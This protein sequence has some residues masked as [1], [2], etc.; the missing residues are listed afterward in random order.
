MSKYFGLARRHLAGAQVSQFSTGEIRNTSAP[1]PEVVGE[2]KKWTVVNVGGSSNYKNVVYN[3]QAWFI[4]Y[5]SNSVGATST[6]GASW[7]V[8]TLASNAYWYPAYGIRNAT[9]GVV[10]YSSNVFNYSTNNG[11]SWTS[12]TMPR[13]ND[14]YIA[15]STMDYC[16]IFTRGGTYLVY[17]TNGTSWTEYSM[18]ANHDVRCVGLG[19]NWNWMVGFQQTTGYKSRNGYNSWTSFTVPSGAKNWSAISGNGRRVLLF[20]GTTTGYYSDDDGGTWTS[21]SL[22]QGF[23]NVIWNG[24]VWLAH[25]LNGAYTS[26]DGITWTQVTSSVSMGYGINS[27]QGFGRQG[28]LTN[29]N[30]RLV[31]PLNTAQGYIAYSDK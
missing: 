19:N 27:P 14:Y 16:S 24:K 15:I 25:Y 22:P 31:L 8:R 10:A 11:V 12:S 30:F 28:N 9:F 3:S 29:G 17:T 4:H 21:M 5:E 26:K 18:P 6:D 23:S 13:S 20:D 2:Y 1:L 7:T